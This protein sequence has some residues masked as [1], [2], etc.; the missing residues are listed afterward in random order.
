MARR[1]RKRRKGTPPDSAPLTGIAA[2]LSETPAAVLDLHG[3]TATQAEARL[4]DFLR[5]RATL[6]PGGVVHVITGRGNRS[7]GTPV[8]PGLVRDLLE[9]DLRDLAVSSAGLPGGGGVAVR[10]PPRDS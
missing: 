9:S 8:L 5:T 7:E 2:L 1:G 6:A 4:R 3:L 10:L